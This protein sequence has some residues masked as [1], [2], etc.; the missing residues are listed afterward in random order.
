MAASTCKRDEENYQLCN[1]LS[2]KESICYN[3]S[4]VS[5][6]NYIL[7]MVSTD[8]VPLTNSFTTWDVG[9][10]SIL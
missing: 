4:P 2:K 8:S 7:H 3:E 9:N 6:G 1:F 5:S 10:Y